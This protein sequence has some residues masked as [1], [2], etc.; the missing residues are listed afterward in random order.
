MT[1][2]RRLGIDPPAGGRAPVVAKGE[3][4]GARPEAAIGALSAS[5]RGSGLDRR[6]VSRCEALRER[7]AT[8]GLGDFGGVRAGAGSEV[9]VFEAVA[10]AFE[11]EDLG[12]VDEPV[13]HRGGGHVVSEDLSPGAERLV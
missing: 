8:G 4:R 6:V 7:P 10:V 12:V 1:P 5:I 13:D 11:G 9:S 3:P 2:W